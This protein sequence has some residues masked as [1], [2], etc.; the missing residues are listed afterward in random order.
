LFG[1]K[2]DNVNRRLLWLRAVKTKKRSH[3]NMAEKRND[4]KSVCREFRLQMGCKG[5]N[6]KY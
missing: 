5:I 1:N 4:V 3:S 2:L 6:R